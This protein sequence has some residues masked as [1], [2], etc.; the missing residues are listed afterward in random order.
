MIGFIGLPPFSA[1]ASGPKQP[2][3]HGE[4]SFMSAYKQGSI[5]IKQDMYTKATN[6]CLRKPNEGLSLWLKPKEGLARISLCL[7]E[8]KDCPCEVRLKSK[9]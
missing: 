5:H 3:T 7:F 6:L 9:K 8:S 1:T 4:D 2:A